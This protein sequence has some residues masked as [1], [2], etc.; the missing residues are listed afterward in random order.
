MYHHN[1][2]KLYY[3]GRIQQESCDLSG[4]FLTEPNTPAL[5]CFNK[6]RKQHRQVDTGFVK[7]FILHHEGLETRDLQNDT[8]RKKRGKKKKTQVR[9]TGHTDIPSEEKRRFLRIWGTAH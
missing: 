8:E 4:K 2:N 6:K 1:D 3:Y 7:G 9:K 5:A